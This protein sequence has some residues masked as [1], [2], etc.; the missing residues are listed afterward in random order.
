MNIG[1]LGGGQLGRM[2]AL[3]GAPLGVRFTFLDPDPACP[4]GQVGPIIV[5]PYDDDA[6]LAQLCDR[7]DVVTFEFENVPAHAA[8]QIAAR[9]PLFPPQ[10]ALETSQ[11]RVLE[12]RC[13]NALGIATPRFEAIDTL[14]GLRSAV[15]TLGLPCVLKTRRF[16]YDGKGQ[17]VIR[18]LDQ[19]DRAWAEVTGHSREA[20]QAASP[21]RR[22]VPALVLES[23]VRFKREL[24]IIGVRG[25]DGAVATYVATA[26]QHLNGILAR[27]DAPALDLSNQTQA[28]LDAAFA[29][30]AHH[31]EYVGVL[32]IEF[33]ELPDGSLVANEMAPRVHNS[34]HWTIEGAQTSQFENHLRAIAGWPLG[35]TACRGGAE[36][37][38]VMLNIVG[39]EPNREGVLSVPGAHLHMYGK[40]ERPGRKLGH[41]TLTCESI[42]ES[43][44]DLNA[45]AET[46]AGFLRNV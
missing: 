6:A 32:A 10:L 26:N 36:G 2:L 5:A 23:F 15:S 39:R 40:G 45:R 3:A 20:E 22:D 30:V 4:A 11:D 7:S 46:V 31:L 24:S 43:R 42:G 9:S 12:K 27:S 18:T 41:V 34:G 19:I 44:E 35:S 13:F 29:K 14:H 8:E 17:F 33:F 1:V 25:R 16:G 38:S 21:A 37:A 28:R